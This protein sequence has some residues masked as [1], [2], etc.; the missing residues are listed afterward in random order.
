MPDGRMINKKIVDNERLAEVPIEA[1]DLFMKMILFLDREGRLSFPANPTL[2]LKKIFPLRDY[3]VEQ[4]EEWLKALAGKRKQGLGLIE[5]YE[6]EGRRYLWMPGFK[7]EQ[8]K[9]WLNTTYNREA[10]SDIPPPPGTKDPPVPKSPDV[11]DI[12]DQRLKEIVKLYGEKIGVPAPD[13]YERLKDIS[14]EY[15][16]EGW[17]EEAV[18]EAVKHNAKSLDYI[19]TILKR[20]RKEG[21]DE[22]GRDKKTR[23]GKKPED[24]PNK[25]IKGKYGHVVQR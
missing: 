22:G 8:S 1:D 13:I 14:K 23:K 25:F 9:S 10:P 17:F 18:S 16:E 7:G 20:Y 11:E 6:V 24:D 3:T 4:I 15:P 21:F 2:I 12:I 5:L 19:E